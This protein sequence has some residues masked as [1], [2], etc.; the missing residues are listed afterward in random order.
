MKKTFCD[1]CGKEIG[2]SNRD[3]S[4][5]SINISIKAMWEDDYITHVGYELCTD[6]AEKTKRTILNLIKRYKK[7]V[8]QV[9]EQVKG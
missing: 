4:E 3:T 7:K 6:C 9:R 1:F 5:P 2:Y 8:K